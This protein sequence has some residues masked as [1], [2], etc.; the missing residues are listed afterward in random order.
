MKIQG[1][2]ITD[3]EMLQYAMM[4]RN[5]RSCRVYLSSIHWLFVYKNIPAL[6]RTPVLHQGLKG[7]FKFAVE[8]MEC[9]KKVTPPLTFD[10]VRKVVQVAKSEGRHQEATLFI[11]ASSFMSRVQDE[12]LPLRIDNFEAH[13]ATS[14]AVEDIYYGRGQKGQ[15]V[16]MTVKLKTRKNC[17]EGYHI[18]RRCVC[19]VALSNVYERD[20]LCPVCALLDYMKNT[21]IGGKPNTKEKIFSASYNHFM[22]YLG[23]CCNIIGMKKS[24]DITT[25]A[26]RR[27]TTKELLDSGKSAAYICLMGGWHSVKSGMLSYIDGA[28]VDCTALF[29]IVARKPKHPN[30]LVMQLWPPCLGKPPQYP[31]TYRYKGERMYRGHT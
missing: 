27:G 2:Q 3:I 29:D 30:S 25:K 21:R 22:H 28:E 11:L 19:N 9:S 20:V 6:W 18:K 7:H 14:F 26:F 4:H 17:R 5:P 31:I 13:S 16:F 8:N 15:A 23:R 1:D 10:L 24:A 12:L